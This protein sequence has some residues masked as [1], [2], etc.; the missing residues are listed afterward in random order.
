MSA[1]LAYEQ[2]D[3]S[4]R[5]NGAVIMSVFAFVWSFGVPGF[6][7]A[8]LQWTALVAALVVTVLL[9]ALAIRGRPVQ[10]KRRMPSDWL[11]RY[12]RVGLVQ[13]VAIGLTIAALIYLGQ[14]A[15][16]PVAVSLIVGVHFF[17]L[18]LVFDQ[19]QCVWT[20]VGLCVVGLI[21]AIT[22]AVASDDEARAL[23]GFGAAMALWATSAHVT[24]RG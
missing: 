7:D 14:P 18:A 22:F 13:V 20:G 3:R 6:T 12:N 15:F 1:E 5:R 16:I 10:R 17:P 24:L 23:V 21:G 9:V 19:P 11:R 2:L 8:T 4:L